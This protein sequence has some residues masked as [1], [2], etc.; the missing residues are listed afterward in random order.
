MGEPAKVFK[1][2]KTPAIGGRVGRRWW[3]LR[4][5]DLLRAE[6]PRARHPYVLAPRSA[7]LRLCGLRWDH[8]E[9][10]TTR[11]TVHRAKG[12]IDSTHPISGD[13]LRELRALHGTQ[14]PDCRFIFM[15]ER[16]ASMSASGLRGCSR[17]LVPLAACRTFI[18]TC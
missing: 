10:K 16:G 3:R 2:R 13:E 11:L 9:W 15:N 4:G 14:E 7:R 8:V 6:C 1:D 18:R 12:S 5:R 17:R